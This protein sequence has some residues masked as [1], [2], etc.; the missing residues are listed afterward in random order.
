MSDVSDAA[1]VRILLADYAAVDVGNKINVVGG[2]LTLVGFNQGSGL[3]APFTVVVSV[4]VPP[5]LYGAECAVEIVL[6]DSAREPVSLPGPT[7]DAQVMR[8]GQ[9]VT[10][11]RPSFPGAYIP[12]ATVGAK[13]QWVLG[14]NTG[15]PLPIG[16]R[17]VWRVRIDH[18]TNDDWVEE[19]FVPG[20]P[21]GPV[22]G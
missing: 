22:L 20:P 9:A 4:M 17:Y 13:V 14:F 15:L 21:P 16:Q 7:G 11:E 12:Q 2:G 8:V 6:E 10:F 18:E 3:T 19:F 5:R 1:L